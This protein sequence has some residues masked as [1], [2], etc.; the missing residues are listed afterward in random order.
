MV[1]VKDSKMQV[2]TNSLYNGSGSLKQV[3]GFFGLWI[4]WPLDWLALARSVASP[5]CLL[6]NRGVLP[7]LLLYAPLVLLPPPPAP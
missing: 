1:H 7:V 4:A 2:V 3:D 6:G 5:I